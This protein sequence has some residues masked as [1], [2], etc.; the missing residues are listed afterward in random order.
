MKYCKRVVLLVAWSVVFGTG[1]TF[2]QEIECDHSIYLSTHISTGTSLYRLT[3]DSVRGITSIEELFTNN[4]DYRIGCLGYSV[5]DKMIYA[6][7]FDT[8][9]LLRI[10]AAGEIVSLGVPNGIDQDLEY[11]SGSIFP[12]GRDFLM[13]GQNKDRREDKAFYSVDIFDMRATPLAI[14]SDGAVNIQDM[15]RDPINGLLY[16]FDNK[17]GTLVDVVNGQ[18]SNFLYP[19]VGERFTSLFFDKSGQLY[20]LGERGE[21]SS[22]KFYE[23]NHVTGE[24]TYIQD[25]PQGNDSDACSCPYTFRFL[26]R[27]TPQKV[28]P[29]GEVTIEYSFENTSG[30]ARTNLRIFD[31]LPPEFEITEIV[32]N[33]NAFNTRIMS[34][35][36]TNVLD[37]TRMEALLGT[38][39]R[40]VIKA[41]VRPDAVGGLYPTQAVLENLPYALNPELES[42]NI[43]TSQPG[44]PNLIEIVEEGFPDFEDIVA[45]DCDN[46]TAILEVPIKNANA[47]LWNDGSDNDSLVVFQSGMYWVDMITDCG[48]V[49]DTILV[50]FERALPFVSLGEDQLRGQGERFTLDLSTNISNVASYSWAAAE[51]DATLSCLDCPMPVFQLTEPTLIEVSVVDE[52]G[53]TYTD[54]IWIDVDKTKL[55]VAPSVFS[56]N[57][58]GVNDLFYLR[59]TNATIEVFRIFDRWGGMVF[60]ARQGTVNEED[61]AW[62]GDQSTNAPLSGVYL[63]HATVLYPDGSREKLAGTVSLLR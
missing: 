28:I 50:D 8:Y 61:H 9:E 49:R 2:G 34:G 46:S 4:T 29:C 27:V 44:D 35:V 62:S 32:E 25:G 26:R 7:E 57:G 53:C 12:G 54:E 31:E 58:D 47:Y 22:R 40:V 33:T 23:I 6:L 43:G 41:K 3:A 45:Y 39:S 1:T 15:A 13:I 17:Q 21:G 10:N 19:S 48:T 42:D 60:E 63:W 59:G 51:V 52:Q 14:I 18:V 37:L 11:Y 20:G 36:G 16:G 30:S 5:V 55:V 24:P 38:K 56:P